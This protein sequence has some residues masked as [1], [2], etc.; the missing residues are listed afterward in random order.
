M[1]NQP[2]KKFSIAS[3]KTLACDTPLLLHLALNAVT[4]SRGSS[5]CTLQYTRSLY[6]RLTSVLVVVFLAV[7][8]SSFRC[9]LPAGI[10]KIAYLRYHVKPFLQ[11]FFVRAISGRAGRVWNR[12]VI[13]MV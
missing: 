4:V 13:A 5:A 12:Y 1:D 6:R 10:Y 8:I 7:R 2:L 11:K 9:R 3:S